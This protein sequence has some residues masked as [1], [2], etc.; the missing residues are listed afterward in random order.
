MRLPGWASLLALGPCAF[1]L[2]RRDY[3]TRD[4]FA[5]HLH[6]SSLPSNIARSLGAQLEGP[7]GSLPDH[8]TFSCPKHLGSSLDDTLQDL[9]RRRK[10]RRSLGYDHISGMPAGDLDPLE[11]ILWHQKQELRQRHVKR[12]PAPPPV[13]RQAVAP[14]ASNV[15]DTEKAAQE[16]ARLQLDEIATTLGIQDPIFKEQWHL[17]NPVQLGHDLNV[18]GVWLD[19]VTGN[20]AITAVIDDGLD[21]Y[22][23]DLKG[24]YFAAGSYD[25]N[26]HTEEPKP[27]LFD[28][29]HGTRCAGEIAA[30]RNNVCGVGMA[31]DS[32]IAGIR[33]LS[34]PISDED[35]A[36]AL[37]YHFQEN[38]IY[39][40]S[41]GPPDDGKTMEGPGILIR[42]AM[43]NGIQQGREGNG[44]VFVFAAGN[45]AASEDNC[46]FDGYTNSIYSITVGGIDRAGNH[47]Y[48]SERCSAQLVVTYSSG[49]NDAIH[50][51]D[52][53]V[54]KCY[55]G[56]GGTSAAGPLVAGSVAL[57]LSVRPDL[58]WRDVQYLVIEAAVPIHLD[59]GDWHETKIGK[60]FSHTFGYG[61][62]DTWQFIEAAKAWKS[63]KPQAWYHSPWLSVQHEIPQGDQ[64]LASSFDVTAAM[65]ETANLE[66]L[67]HV[68]VT[69]NI[70][71][72]RR[73]DLS[74]ELRSPEGIVSHIAT[75]RRYD[76]AQ[77]GYDDWTFMSVV[78]WGE[79]GIGTWTVIVKD[80]NVNDLNGTFTD[81]RLNLWGEC[82]DPIIQEL[83]PMPDEHDDDHEI[84]TPDISTTSIA[85]PSQTD[86]PATPTDHIDR[87]TKPKPDASGTTT[88]A[89]PPSITLPT[90]TSEA[91][92]AEPTHTVSDSF[93]PSFFPTFG[94]GPKTQ[95]WIYGSIV[96]IVLF[97]A[98]LGAYFLAVQRRQR[99]NH[100]RDDY[101]FE[102]LD[103]DD[104]DAP[105]MNGHAGGKK[106]K[107]R[108]GELYDAF[109]GESSDEALF[110]DEDEQYKDVPRDGEVQSPAEKGH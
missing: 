36:T 84:A 91:E 64:G 74:V 25:F 59:D 107:R 31:Y 14:G 68:T 19:G 75:T 82:I 77:A 49:N 12:V 39:S 33:I 76:E 98:G 21:M 8:Y 53:G 102:V 63:V 58:S 73:G 26:E 85:A 7:L 57:A 32:K 30:V 99:R 97:C 23:D 1:A 81:W 96:L 90:S 100:P 2:Q 51:T 88:L 93:L 5:V 24:N 28:D 56:H 16:A 22:S 41:W 20:G 109:A 106:G 61:K 4:Y 87:P 70:K 10:R 104:P 48:Y 94:V 101:E 38:Q 108:A 103:D 54:D 11:G 60:K 69:M 18:T 3:D 72:M 6:G 89:T 17:F 79:T 92:V 15:N 52:V 95:I 29:K 110:S 83:H 34:K 86:L 13:S 105:G 45:G 9:R 42:R 62:M 67:E 47:P 78:H 40:C 65:L 80:T 50:T 43:L 27:R 55:N 46:N 66:R 35:E 44:S 37:N 71:H